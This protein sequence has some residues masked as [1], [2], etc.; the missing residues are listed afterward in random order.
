[1]CHSVRLESLPLGAY[2]FLV[3]ACEVGV[4]FVGETSISASANFLLWL[5]G[6]SYAFAEGE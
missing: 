1:M 5:K 4:D 6:E 2:F 3:A